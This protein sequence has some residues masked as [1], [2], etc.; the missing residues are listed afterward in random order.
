MLISR[1]LCYCSA[2][3]YIS[4][5][6]SPIRQIDVRAVNSTSATVQWPNNRIY[7]NKSFQVH[8]MRSGNLAA[9]VSY[10]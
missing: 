2:S 10:I 6:P 9:R 4:V 7:Y 3:Y 5:K 8:I 1:Y